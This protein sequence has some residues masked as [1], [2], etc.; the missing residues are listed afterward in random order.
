MWQ[1][2]AAVGQRWVAWASGVAVAIMVIATA[3]T[4]QAVPTS[5]DPC[6]TPITPAPAYCVTIPAELP[7]VALPPVALPTLPN[8]SLPKVGSGSEWNGGISVP[9]VTLPKPGDL[10]GRSSLPSLPRPDN[11]SG[12]P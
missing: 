3:P 7:P 8:L 1:R 5:N 9:R 2:I 4:A 10:P 12:L 11:T 6:I